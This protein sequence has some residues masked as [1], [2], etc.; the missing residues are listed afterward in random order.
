MKAPARFLVAAAALVVTMA[1]AGI[2]NGGPEDTARSDYQ[3]K[4][5]EAI[6]S[7]VIESASAASDGIDPASPASPPAL[8]QDPET[9]EKYHH[10]LRAYYDYRATG[11]EHR[12]AVFKWQ[13]FS[14]KLIFCIVLIVVATGIILAI[15]QFR[16]EL[17]LV[18]EGKSTAL[19]KSEL[20][21]SPSGIKVSS[22]IVGI[23]ILTLSLAFFYFYLV[24]VYPI[25]DIF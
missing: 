23:I 18:R 1:V 8:V 15:M 6:E 5:D 14:A 24:Y 13:L 10:A 7:G 11:L 19:S 4:L 3:K 2:A 16:A 21:A 12:K 17:E 25:E 20:E 22:S 9:L